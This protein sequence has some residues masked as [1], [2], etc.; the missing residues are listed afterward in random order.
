M[1][2]PYWNVVLGVSD[3]L[4]SPQQGPNAGDEFARAERLGEVIVGAEFEADDALGLFGAR[5]EHD[6]WQR[7]RWLARAQHAA[8]FQ[9]VDLRQHQVEDEQIR[10]TRSYGLQRLAPGPDELGREAGFVEIARDELGD[11]GVV[12]DDE[13]SHRH[14]R[15][16]FTDVDGARAGWR[17]MKLRA[18]R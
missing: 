13:D 5:R 15:D 1:S 8:H 10:G 16:Y 2:G 17:A 6:D 7:R 14:D 18:E 3:A 12:L 9:T 11:V 4:R